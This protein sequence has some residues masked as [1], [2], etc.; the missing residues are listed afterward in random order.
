M[1]AAVLA[2]VIVHAIVADADA[3]GVD[4][5]RSVKLAG[6]QRG[7]IDDHLERGAGLAQR[8]GGAIELARAIIPAADDR[9]DEPI[10]F[11]DDRAA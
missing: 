9:A 6:H 3:G 8:V 2:V 11:R 10:G 7:E 5:R 4:R 1:R